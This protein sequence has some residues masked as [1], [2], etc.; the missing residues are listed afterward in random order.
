MIR[1]LAILLAVA[2]APGAASAATQPIQPGYWESTNRVLS[3][4]RQT[5]V[6]RRCIKPADVDKFMSGPSNRHYAC[7]YPTKV[8]ADGKIL[9]KGACRSKKGR[10]V[11]I[12]GHGT[13]SPTSFALT[14]D[15]AIEFLGLD[16]AG[17]ATTEAHRIGDECPA[18]DAP[19]A[20]PPTE[21]SG[22]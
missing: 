9:L 21:P 5:T 22:R 6:E 7:T 11:G 15:V 2:A 20:A 13:Y 16:I 4:I 1:M 8:F 10:K 17:R 3:P 12:E 19:P 18:P 14:A